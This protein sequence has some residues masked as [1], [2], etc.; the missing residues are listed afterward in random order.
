MGVVYHVHYLD[1]FEAGRTE[2]LR[3][4]G[5]SYKEIEDSGLL[6][7]VIEVNVRYRKPAFYDDVLEILTSIEQTTP[8]RLILRNEVRRVGEQVEPDIL[9]EGRITLCFVNT[10]S[11]RP[12]RAPAHLL[13]MLDREPGPAGS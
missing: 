5:V 2:L 3:E 6:I 7:Q 12:V 9:V 13:E 1:H 10:E 4:N 8:T 11:G